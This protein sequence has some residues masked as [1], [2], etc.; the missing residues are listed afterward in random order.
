MLTALLLVSAHIMRYVQ[1]LKAF[2]PVLL[3]TPA[4]SAATALLSHQH[5]CQ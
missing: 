5:S 2:M 3:S 4:G 1:V